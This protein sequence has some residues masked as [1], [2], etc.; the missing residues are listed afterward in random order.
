[1]RDLIKE[2]FVPTDPEKY[3]PGINYMI[4]PDGRRVKL[5]EENWEFNHDRLEPG[6]IVEDI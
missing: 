6:F 2:N 1:M 4:R 3:I 5:T